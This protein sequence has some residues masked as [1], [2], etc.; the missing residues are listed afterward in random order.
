MPYRERPKAFQPTHTFEMLISLIDETISSYSPK[1]RT[2]IQN[3]ARARE[4]LHKLQEDLSNGQKFL[5]V[6]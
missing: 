1:E 5:V 6:A 4:I 2:P 3:T